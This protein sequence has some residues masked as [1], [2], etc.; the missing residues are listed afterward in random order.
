MK[1]DALFRD[2]QKFTDG[3]TC[4][5]V[6]LKPTRVVVTR[7]RMRYHWKVSQL[8]YL[9]S[10]FLCTSQTCLYRQ[11]DFQHARFLVRNFKWSS[12]NATLFS[13]TIN[14]NMAWKNH[15]TVEWMSR[16]H[17]NFAGEL[18]TWTIILKHMTFIF[19]FHSVYKPWNLQTCWK[20]FG[21]KCIGMKMTLWCADKRRIC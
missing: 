5:C 13:S 14:I 18:E 21:Y 19:L 15:G 8:A 16:T 6:A 2:R 4:C 20:L 17:A 1:S 7:S 12:Y 11:V 10:R 3:Y 9:P